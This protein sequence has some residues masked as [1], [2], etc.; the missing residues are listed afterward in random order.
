MAVER[1]I[2]TGE[3]DAVQFCGDFLRFAGRRGWSLGLYLFLGAMVE[4]IGVLLLLPLLGVVLGA[5]T[6]NRWIDGMTDSI[7]ALAP[8]ETTAWKLAFILLLF[9]LLVAFRS[10]I[11]LNRDILIERLQTGFVETLRFRII[12]SLAECRWEVVARLKHGRIT[13][14]LGRDLDQCGNAALL[15]LRS[16]VAVAMLVGQWVLVFMLSATL[17]MLALLLFVAA[18]LAM[19]P[20]LQRSVDLGSGLAE[21]NLD[22]I[23]ETGQFLGGLKL[24][25][26]QNLQHGFLS[27]FRRVQEEVMWRRIAF[28]RQRTM[29]QLTLAVVVALLGGLIILIGVGLL[30]TPPAILFA[31]LFVLARLSGPVSQIQASAQLIFH[32]LPTYRKVKDLQADLSAKAISGQAPKGQVPKMEWDRLELT[33]VSY[34]HAGS[35][36]AGVKSFTLRISPGEVVGLS[37]PSGA[38]K[39]TVADLIVGLYAPQAGTIRVGG[40]RLEGSVLAGWRETLSYVSQDPFLFHDSI[41]RNLQ[42]ACPDA[43]DDEMWRVLELAGA[44]DLIRGLGAGLDTIVGERGTLLSGGERQRIAL[45]RALI[46]KPGL[47][48]LDEATSAIDLTGERLILERVRGSVPQLAIL[49]IAH[50]SETLALTDRNIELT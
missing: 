46:R 43:S 19:R 11:I 47:L 16:A 13:Q 35:E 28:T 34:I 49:M 22:M 9:A 24:A 38:G 10:F 39:T 33:D 48:L 4:G 8:G 32:S 18:A 42:W 5:G 50:R 37:G 31:F 36:R 45:A 25:L 20:L 17:A 1:R 15:L 30:G 41:R 29:T 7:V 23:V 14:I 26:S 3:H 6:G 2:M 40:K 21:S 12:S 27:E 44:A